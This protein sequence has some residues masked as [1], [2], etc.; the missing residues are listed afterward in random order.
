MNK[1][2]FADVSLKRR[3]EN[4]ILSKSEYKYIENH[5][6]AWMLENG[7]WTNPY[8]I[9]IEQVRSKGF[10]WTNLTPYISLISGLVSFQFSSELYQSICSVSGWHPYKQLN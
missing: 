8:S 7:D 6:N 2:N 3:N 9:Y 1:I 5:K 4:F 10:R